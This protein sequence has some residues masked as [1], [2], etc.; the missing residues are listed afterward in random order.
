MAHIESQV[1]RVIVA[2]TIATTLQL[3]SSL[4]S[5]SSSSSSSRSKSPLKSEHCELVTYHDDYLVEKDDEPQHAHER[6]V[7]VIERM[8]CDEW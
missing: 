5:S 6:I 8:N 4:H 1:M 3:S 2:T 7:W